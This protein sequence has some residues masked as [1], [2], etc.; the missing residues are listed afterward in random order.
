MSTNLKSRGFTLIEG[1]ITIVLL[2]IAMITLTS[3]LFPQLERSAIPMYQAKSA[4]IADAVF[5]EILSRQ[6]DQNSDPLGDS[7]YRCG[8]AYPSAVSDAMTT[9]LCAKELGP[10]DELEKDQPQYSNDVDDFI[11]CWGVLSQ[12]ETHQG[13]E[14]RAIKD[15]ESSLVGLIPGVSRSEYKHIAVI[16]NVNYVDNSHGQFKLVSAPKAAA[17]LVP[18]KQISVTVDAGRYGS[19]QYKALRGNY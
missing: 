13:V 6:F 15:K 5:N 14:Y 3:F 18:L 8:E 10:D 19:Y 11:G 16:V 17:E 2:A 12:C 1:I 7:V 9:N 4:A